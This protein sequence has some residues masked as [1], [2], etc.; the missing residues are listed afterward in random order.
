MPSGNNH[1]GKTHV[2]YLKV[3][4]G[5]IYNSIPD[6]SEKTGLSYGAIYNAIQRY[7]KEAR[8]KRYSTLHWKYL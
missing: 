1:K 8:W 3:E 7:G 4:T 5:D 6:A 2:L